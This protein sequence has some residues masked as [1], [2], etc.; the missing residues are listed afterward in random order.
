MYRCWYGSGHRHPPQ[1]PKTEPELL[2]TGFH[3]KIIRTFSPEI[4]RRRP[5]S[6]TNRSQKENGFQRKNRAENVTSLLIK[7]HKHADLLLCRRI[8]CV[9]LGVPFVFWQKLER[10][11]VAVHT[12]VDALRATDVHRDAFVVLQGS[13]IN[14]QTCV[15]RGTVTAPTKVVVKK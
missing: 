10:H 15:K 13:H 1:Q 4:R 14:C 3:D 2:S 9:I 7:P 8:R 12:P 6:T 5:T 11:N